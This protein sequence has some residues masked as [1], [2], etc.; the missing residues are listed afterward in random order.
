MAKLRD[1]VLVEA[2]S[3]LGLSSSGVERLPASLLANGLA[4]RIRF[5]SRRYV[6]PLPR[7]GV[8]DPE[9]GTLNADAIRQYT[10]QLA[11]VIETRRRHDHI[12][13]G[14]KT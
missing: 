13:G 6:A 10:V 3:T 2:P 11:D 14:A 1:A 9:S 7:S 5:R 12:L 8:R 4:D